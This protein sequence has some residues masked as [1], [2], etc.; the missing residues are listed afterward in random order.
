MKCKQLL[1]VCLM[2][3]SISLSAHKANQS[4][5]YLDVLR[6]GI[7]GTFQV[8]T[9]D[10]NKSLDLEIPRGVTA[11]E[12]DPYLD[13][14]KEYL[15]EEIKI[16]DEGRQELAVQ[17]TSLDFLDLQLGYYLLLNFELAQLDSIPSELYIDYQGFISEIQ[18]HQGFVLISNNWKAGIHNNEA[19]PSLVYD[20]GNLGPQRLDLEEGS[21][22]RGFVAMVRSGMWHIWI[23][24]DHILFLLALLLPSVMYRRKPEDWS[25]KSTIT[26]S[27]WFPVESFKPAFLY[28]LKIV[29]LFTVAHSITL[30]LASLQIVN[31]PSWLVESVIAISIALAAFHNIRPFLKREALV[32]AFG[33]GLFHGFGFA[34]VLGEVGIQGEYLIYTILGFNIGVEICQ[35][36]IILVLFPILFLIRKT[37]IYR[38]LLIYGSIFLIIM[39]LNWT[40]ERTFDINLLFDDYLDKAFRRFKGLVGI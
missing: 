24:L 11:E 33:F 29:T 16:M 26:A 12:L 15:V 20:A 39:A 30:S 1:I 6:K 21:I 5:L 37:P 38:P 22:W 3:S 34:S 4:Y 2:L 18:D 14:I 8:T 23:G 35:I 32:I 36:L 13:L 19:M 40:I 9:E 28:V 7:Q 31:L 17:F 27:N 10:I 25:L